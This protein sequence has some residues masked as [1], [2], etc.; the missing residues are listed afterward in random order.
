MEIGKLLIMNSI[1]I[2]VSENV[3]WSVLVFS[4]QIF[5]IQGM[6]YLLAYNFSLI[7]AI[8]LYILISGLLL[9]ILFILYDNFKDSSNRSDNVKL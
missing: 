7:F 3:I 8:F 1:L 4:D 5:A 9:L 2:A 6:S